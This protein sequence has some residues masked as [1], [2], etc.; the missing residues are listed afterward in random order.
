MYQY[1]IKKPKHNALSIP[2]INHANHGDIFIR[3]LVTMFMAS[4]I[5]QHS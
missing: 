4:I 3:F 1:H 5:R 2:D